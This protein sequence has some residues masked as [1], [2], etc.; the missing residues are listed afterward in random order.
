MSRKI[1]TII[2]FF[3]NESTLPIMLDSILNGILVP[4]EI[5]LI[6]DGSTDSSANIAKD[7]QRKNSFIRYY[8]QNH[9]GVSAARNLGI[10]NA[11]GDWISFLDADDFIEKNMY[12]AMIDSLD[13]NPECMGCIAGYYTEK[14]GISTPYV[15]TESSIIK[16]Q[17]LLEKMFSN[18]NIRGFLFTRLFHINLFKNISFDS[19]IKLCEDLL[20]QTQLFL[21][22]SDVQFAVC[23]EPVYH[24]VQNTS[25]ATNSKNLFKNGVFIYQPAFAKIHT[26]LNYN[27]VTETYKQIIEFNMYNALVLYKNGQKSALAQ[28]NLLKKELRKLPCGRISI[29]GLLYRT[30][31]LLY[32]YFI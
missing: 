24:Y 17:D 9:A 15:Y 20:F 11:T 12:K 26:L 16:S 3:N 28:I 21:S 14:N 6:D 27:Y 5:I 8:Y 19:E 25:S 29:H 23:Q 2:P 13:D 10:S 18:D 30:W 32:I 22:N 7:Y 31:P 1:T 4:D